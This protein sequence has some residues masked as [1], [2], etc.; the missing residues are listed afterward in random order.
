MASGALGD[1]ATSRP[2]QQQQQQQMRGASVPS[3]SGRMVPTPML[4]PQPGMAPGG[5]PLMVGTGP[6]SGA[7]GAQGAPPGML[8]YP[9]QSGGVPGQQG[10]ARGG[11]PGQPG[12]MGPGGRQG[13]DVSGNVLLDSSILLALDSSALL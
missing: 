6:P 12:A 3:G 4:G 2:Q 11:A 9:M 10:G 1:E 8:P 7:W 13:M 5:A